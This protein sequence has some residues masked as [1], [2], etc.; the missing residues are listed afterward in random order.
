MCSTITGGSDKTSGTPGTQRGVVLVAALFLMVVLAALG[1][2][3]MRVGG[4]QQQTVNLGLLSDRAVAAANSGIEYGAYQVVV[5]KSCMP[6][7]PKIF[8]QA[9]LVGFTADVQCVPV[10]A[11]FDLTA[12]ASSGV[13]GSL[14]YVSRTVTARCSSTG[15]P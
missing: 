5:A 7:Y 9:G 6:N 14:D 15:C 13:Y 4:A 12:T 11:N 3:A 2:F 1:L 8:N 10:G